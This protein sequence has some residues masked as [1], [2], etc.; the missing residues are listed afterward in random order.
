MSYEIQRVRKVIDITPQGSIREAIEVSYRTSRG[1]ESWVR[2]PTDQYDPQRI[3][4]MI[5]EESR[6]LD[7]LY[8][9]S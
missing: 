7:S 2:V 5:E 1:A 3:R 9:G 6:K 4:Q 8:G